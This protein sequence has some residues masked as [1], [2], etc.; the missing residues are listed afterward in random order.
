MISSLKKK[1]ENK[2]E[3]GKDAVLPRTDKV[4]EDGT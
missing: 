3:K 4:F 1:S 2:G